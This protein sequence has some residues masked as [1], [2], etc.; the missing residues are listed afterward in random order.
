MWEPEVVTII[1]PAG[2]P[3]SDPDLTITINRNDLEQT[4]M[5]AK[6]MAAQIADGTAKTEGDATI[7]EKLASTF[8]DFQIGF[9][10]MPGTGGTPSDEKQ[11]P[12]EV[13]PIDV[14]GE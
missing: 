4:L 10:I 13:D 5:G 14:H 8:V 7:L 1:P 11:D 3:S 9:E 6:T 2:A 12:F